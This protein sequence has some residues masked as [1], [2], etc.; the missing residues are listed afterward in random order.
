M[1]RERGVRKWRVRGREGE[2][3]ARGER[4]EMG[5]EGE[6]GEIGGGRGR[7]GG[8]EKRD[9]AKL[10]FHVGKPEAERCTT[11]LGSDTRSEAF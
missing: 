10:S 3:G 9:S 1:V 2:E 6:G 8:E 11:F 4:G 7:E 5:R